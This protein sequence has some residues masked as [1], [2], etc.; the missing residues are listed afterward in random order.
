M[1]RQGTEREGCPRSTHFK[2]KGNKDK[3]CKQAII[4][5]VFTSHV[6]AKKPKNH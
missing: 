6:K 1:A 3:I 2:G 4:K 5:C